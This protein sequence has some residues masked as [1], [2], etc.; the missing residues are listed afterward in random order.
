MLTAF[1]Q[2]GNSIYLGEKCVIRNLYNILHEQIN[3]LLPV[4]NVRYQALGH[5]IKIWG[6]I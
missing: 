4:I 1:I 2:D 6:N 3:V 5:S